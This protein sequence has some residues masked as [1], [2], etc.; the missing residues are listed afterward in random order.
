MKVKVADA[1]EPIGPL[2][3]AFIA[4]WTQFDEPWASPKIDGGWGRGWPSAANTGPQAAPDWPG[5]LT[6]HD[7]AEPILSNSTYAFQS[8]GGLEIGN[9]TVPVHNVHLHG[10]SV[11][12]VSVGGALSTLYADG[13]VAIT[14]C[15]FGPLAD[16]ELDVM[17][18]YEESV[19]YGLTFSGAYSTF[20]DWLLLDSSLWWGYGNSIDMGNPGS[21]AETPVTIRHCAI[22][23]AADDG[24]ATASAGQYH[25]D[26]PGHL[27][28]LGSESHLTIEHC[29]IES[30]GN[31]NG[32][33]LQGPSPPVSFSDITIRQNLLGCYGFTV[34][35]FTPAPRTIFT[36]N[37]FTTRLQP[38]Y[39]PLYPQDFWASEGSVWAR[40]R[41]WVPPGAA[42]GNPA[43]NGRYWIPTLGSFDMNDATPVAWDT[44]RISSETDYAG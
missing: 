32:I 33:A 2:N 7:P 8:F 1:L 17:V 29:T 10:C 40:N 12:D 23:T 4:R 22:L 24:G 42:W 9:P 14:F 11:R 19:Q 3:E 31:T 18:P 44:A 41:L 36:D 39:G 26:G 20:H 28:G 38:L 34:S 37:V 5:A 27:T 43:H 6:P 30:P 21:S 25:T 35:L 13:P 16:F 15:E